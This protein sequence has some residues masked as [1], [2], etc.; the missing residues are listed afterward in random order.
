MPPWEELFQTQEVGGGHD[1]RE[2]SGLV[3]KG[4][5]VFVHFRT[6]SHVCGSNTSYFQ[7]NSA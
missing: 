7:V 4:Y 2:F 1:L 5:I 3:R 6:V